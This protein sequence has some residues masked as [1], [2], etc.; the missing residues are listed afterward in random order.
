LNSKTPILRIAVFLMLGLGVAAVAVRAHGQASAP[1]AAGHPSTAASREASAAAREDR[2]LKEA[3]EGDESGENVYR[4]SKLVKSA[5]K[6]LG[7]KVETTA[8]TFEFINFAIVALGIGIPLA[9]FLPKMLRSRAAKLS[10]DIE[11][12]RKETESAN[13]RLNAVEEKL[14]HLDDEIAKYRAEIESE[15]RKDEERSKEAIEAERVRIVASAE[16][17]IGVAA[18]QARRGLRNL[19]AELAIEQAKQ[20]LVLTPESDRALIAEFVADAGKGGR[21]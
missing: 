2:A 3:E 8:R 17:E 11:S 14:K 5:A 7:W 9:R 1:E 21:N 19:A 13:S 18:A 4:H 12:A 20:K 16:Q 10:S 6:A 15:M